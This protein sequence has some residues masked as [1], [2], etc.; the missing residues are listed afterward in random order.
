MKSL[1]IAILLVI[2]VCPLTMAGGLEPI[3]S[4]GLRPG[5]PVQVQTPTTGSSDFKDSKGRLQRQKK[6]PGVVEDRD[7]K[8]TGQEMQH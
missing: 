7:G 1:F 4:S 6:H 5:A 3:P 8:S 2:F